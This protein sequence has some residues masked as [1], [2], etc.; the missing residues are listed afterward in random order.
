MSRSKMRPREKKKRS[1]SRRSTLNAERSIQTSNFLEQ[2]FE[3]LD[4]FPFPRV[5][6][7]GNALFGGAVFSGRV[8]VEHLERVAATGGTRDHSLDV[9]SVNRRTWRWFSGGAFSPDRCDQGW[10]RG[11]GGERRHD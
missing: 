8:G 3:E 6:V 4:P 1:M 10:R 11:H 7:E 5:R 2:D 9:F